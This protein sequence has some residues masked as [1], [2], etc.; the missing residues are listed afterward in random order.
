MDKEYYLKL[1]KDFYIEKGVVPRVKDIA[2]SS[3]IRRLF[4]TWNNAI[5]SAGLV[6]KKTSY[7]DKEILDV[8]VAFYTKNNK[9][10]RQCDITTPSS[11]TIINRF[12]TWNNA[13]IKANIPIEYNIKRTDEQLLESIVNFYNKNGR[14]PTVKDC[15]KNEDMP[16][17]NTIIRRFGSWNCAI[18]SAGL[19]PNIND[20]FGNRCLGPD[21]NLYRSNAE[22][23]FV[24]NFLFKKIEY[25]V[26]PKYPKPYH[27]KRYDWYI[28][29]M[30]LYIELDGGCRPGVI[31][32]K[33][34]IN[35]L[36]G[37]HLLVIQT[38]DIYGK[39]TL[40]DFL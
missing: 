13:L 22:V 20:G 8:L 38:K 34:Q 35:N 19:T 32:E 36:L 30:N 3:K 17:A 29:H 27:K 39:A 23:Y 25:I 21:N 9:T 11:V 1:I 15:L 16:G 33:I 6:S 4:G 14:V 37:R 24:T 7:T 5:E 10:P 12:G 40:Q 2:E 31:S 28:P 26:E 18:L